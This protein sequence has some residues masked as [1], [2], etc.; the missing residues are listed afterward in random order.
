MNVRN[1]VYSYVTMIIN[2]IM[3]AYRYAHLKLKY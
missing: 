1:H 2:I 3:H